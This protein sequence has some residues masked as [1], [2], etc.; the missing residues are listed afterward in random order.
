MKY[1]D[2]GL[3]R[4]LN[5][6]VD[7]IKGAVVSIEELQALSDQKEKSDGLVTMASKVAIIGLVSLSLDNVKYVM[8]DIDER[9]H[10]LE[11]EEIKQNIILSTD[12][13]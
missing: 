13:T 12:I 3:K 6:M 4:E 10:L 1:T 9:L 7:C 8:M 11:K 2:E 5:H